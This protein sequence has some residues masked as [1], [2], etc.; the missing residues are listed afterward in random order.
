MQQNAMA[1][2]L[3]ASLGLLRIYRLLEIT[4]LSADQKIS[5]KNYLPSPLY[6]IIPLTTP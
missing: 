6:T 5:V 4:P 1:I 3:K 2:V